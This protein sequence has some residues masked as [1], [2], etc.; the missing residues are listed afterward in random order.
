MS[1][2]NFN[3]NN[4]NIEAQRRKRAENFRLNIQDNF[5]D[6]SDD[7]GYSEPSEINSYSGEEA[8]EKIARDS[9]NAL[10]RK[11]KEEKKER[12]AKNKPNRRV[13]RWL[14][15]ASVVI[16]GVMFSLF[17]ITGM[18]DMLAIKRTDS[19]KVVVNIP[20]N[21][22]LDDVTDELVKKGVI[23]EFLYFEMYASMTDSADYFNQGTYELR[24]N[25]DY[26][27]IISNLQSSGNRQDIVSVTII[28]GQNVL[29]VA[30]T[31]KDNKALGDVDKF[32]ELCKSDNFDEDF[33]FLK[34]IKNKDE[35]YYKLE[36]YLYPDKYDFYV[37][38]DPEDIIYKFLNNYENKISEK[39][40]V[41]NH[42]KLTTVKKMVE[43][44][45]I[46]YTLD[47]VMN[48]AS[49]IQAEAANTEDMYYVSSILHNRLEA[50]VDMG[51]SNL[52][53]D[54][55]RF[56]PYRNADTV[57]EN[58]GEDYVSKYDTYDNSGLPAGPICSPGMEAI[59][60]A[61]NP[62][63]TGYYFFCHDSQGQA[64]YAETLYGQESNLEYIRSYDE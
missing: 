29:E 55:T 5:D 28:E 22:T 17:I 53:L 41:W 37:N 43:E 64:Y 14:W 49:I 38:E 13:F 32:L 23:D 25:M 27:A 12:K 11:K 34:D 44:S 51:V 56:Y 33:F 15:V 6:A 63:D 10:K 18:N 46:G 42:E 8:R 57:P 35:R 61:L 62:Y 59:K 60:A 30:N 40:D 31:L 24:K 4:R 3:F 39:Q 48:I 2:D 1:Q 58:L 26:Q 20:E 47:E 9:K 50:D 36:G 19:S 54:S 21:P 52:G 7:N 16:V 45:D